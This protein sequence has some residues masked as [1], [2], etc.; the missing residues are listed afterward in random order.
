MNDIKQF[1]KFAFNNKKP[2]QSSVQCGCVYCL[3]IFAPE[4]IKHWIDAKDIKRQ[5]GQT[6]LCPYCGVDSIIPDDNK[7][8]TEDIL[9]QAKEYWFSP[10]KKTN[11]AKLSRES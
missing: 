1:A 3:K 6:A 8:L 9:K 4:E 10:K 7:T 11:Y 2:L 5:E